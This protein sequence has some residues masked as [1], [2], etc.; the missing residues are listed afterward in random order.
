MSPGPAFE[1]FNDPRQPTA[2]EA[3]AQ[4]EH[5]T[6][7]TAEGDMLDPVVVPDFM[8]F[9]WGFEAKKKMKKKT[10]RVLTLTGLCCMLSPEG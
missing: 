5:S 6:G 8:R 4:G 7:A 2:C 10:K 3:Y 9:Y 1:K